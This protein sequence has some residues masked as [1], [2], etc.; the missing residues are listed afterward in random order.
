MACLCHGGR[1][2]KM[3]KHHRH[4][5]EI[6]TAIPEGKRLCRP[7]AVGH[8]SDHGFAT[9]LLHHLLR[10]VYADYLDAEMR[11]Q[12]FGKT[13]GAASEINDQ[14][15][16][17]SINMNREQVLPEPNGFRRECASLVIGGRLQLL[18]MSLSPCFRPAEMNSRIG[19]YSAAHAAFALRR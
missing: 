4:E 11:G 2:S 13:S 5:Y 18:T 8:I 1:V 12:K 17:G 14:R 7:L 6:G 16:T 10:W 15:Y 9:S 19:Q 3:V